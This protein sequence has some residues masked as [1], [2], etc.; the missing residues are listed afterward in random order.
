MRVILQELQKAYH[1][2]GSNGGF[3]MLAESDL[4]KLN[5]ALTQ[6]NIASYA[7]LKDTI[8]KILRLRERVVKESAAP[9]LRSLF[10]T[11]TALAAA[12]STDMV[13][14]STKE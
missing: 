5:D 8:D 9:V 3:A 14:A 13:G 2:L 4:N 10:E 1:D 12:I 6:L 11:S 7:I